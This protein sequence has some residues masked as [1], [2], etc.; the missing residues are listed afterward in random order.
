MGIVLNSNLKLTKETER[1]IYL[2]KLILV[3]FAYGGLVLGSSKL[4]LLPRLPQKMMLASKVVKRD[5]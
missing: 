1:F 2:D 3:K 4:L 5:F